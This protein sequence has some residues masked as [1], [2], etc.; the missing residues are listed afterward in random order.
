M[1]QAKTFATLSSS[2]DQTRQTPQW[3]FDRLHT[4][5]DFTL[6]PC[7]LPDSAKCERFHTPETDGL[8]ASWA[9]ERCYV[10]PPY[11]AAGKWLAKCAEADTAVVLVPARPGTQYW[12]RDVWPKAKEVMFMRGR[13]KFDRKSGNPAVLVPFDTALILF[14]SGSFDGVADLGFRIPLR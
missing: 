5:F 1:D 9:G 3:L 14:G 8:S 6:D 7:C 11:N 12:H 4:V 13:V 10:N 2:E